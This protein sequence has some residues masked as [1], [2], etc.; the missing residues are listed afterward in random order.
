MS[1]QDKLHELASD[2]KAKS[3]H[4]KTIGDTYMSAVYWGCYT[5]VFYAECA[6]RIHRFG[7]VKE[8]EPE[9]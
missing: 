1:Y 6:Y 2:Y 9:F 5:G 7:E 3:E 8:Q 4:Y